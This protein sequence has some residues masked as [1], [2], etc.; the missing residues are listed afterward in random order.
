MYPATAVLNCDVLNEKAAEKH[1]HIPYAKRLTSVLLS[2]L[3]WLSK[4]SVII[5]YHHVLCKT[6]HHPLLF[7][8]LPKA[9]PVHFTTIVYDAVYSCQGSVDLYWREFLHVA[10]GDS[11]GFKDDDCQ[12]AD[13][14]CLWHRMTLKSRQKCILKRSGMSVSTD[15]L[16]FNL[17]KLIFT[18][19]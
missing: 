19:K 7:V 4:P 14:Q 2:L 9:P 13:M 16:F 15:H 18:V 3:I 1:T 17:P 11:H 10:F 8:L 6:F 5:C 12:H